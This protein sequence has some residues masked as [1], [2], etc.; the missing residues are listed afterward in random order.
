MADLR[1][2]EGRVPPASRK[3]A[4][5]VPCSSASTL[6]LCTRHGTEGSMARS[7]W[8]AGRTDAP[9]SHRDGKA[10]HP[11]L[12]LL[13]LLEDRPASLTDSPGLETDFDTTP[14]AHFAGKSA[15]LQDSVRGSYQ[16]F[17]S[18]GPLSSR[19]TR[20]GFPARTLA[21][22]RPLFSNALL[23]LLT[24]CHVTT[25]CSKSRVVT[26]HAEPREYA[27]H[28]FNSRTLGFR[29]TPSLR[30]CPRRSSGACVI[31]SNLSKL[32]IFLDFSSL[33]AALGVS[34]GADP[35]TSP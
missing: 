21:R 20:T 26:R 32:K 24:S 14:G 13:P 11:N 18:P 16:R 9:A 25:S 3:A 34:T 1:A 12:F 27:Q 30:P 23:A 33:S 5:W 4:G 7:P 2:F 22:R 35:Q 6:C 10:A 19:E 29:M 17:V 31:N 8:L 15:V 28:G